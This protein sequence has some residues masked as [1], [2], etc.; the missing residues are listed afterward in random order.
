MTIDVSAYTNKGSRD[1]NEDSMLYTDKLFIVADGLGGHNAGEEASA[2]AVNYIKGNL[3]SSYSESSIMD[4]IE[5]ANTA[6]CNLGSD[7]LTTVAMAIIDKGIFH[8]A[9]V[10]DSRVYLFRKNKLFAYTKDHSVCQVSVDMGELKYED[11]RGNEDRSKLLKVL[12]NPAPVKLKKL[13]QPIRLQDGDA[14]IICTDG[15]WENIYET[16]METDLLKA[17]NAEDW[18]T[19]MIKRLLLKTN[20]IGDNYTAICGIYHNPNAKAAMPVLPDVSRITKLPYFKYIAAGIAALI[21]IIIASAIISSLGSDSTGGGSSENTQITTSITT[22]ESSGETDTEE[23]EAEDLPS[24]TSAPVSESEEITTVTCASISETTAQTTSE[25]VI[26]TTKP[27]T[28][29]VVTTT[30]PP[31][32]TTK[33]K[34]TKPKPSTTTAPK[35]TKPKTTT[36]TE[37]KDEGYATKATTDEDDSFFNDLPETEGPFDSTIPA[38]GGNGG[39]IVYS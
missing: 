39:G 11:I 32:T 15:F 5:K 3:G 13:Y 1:V 7:G 24:E 18:L 9:N 35:S 26:T 31:A 34:T 16:E 12:G 25:T 22:E 23:T 29:P 21:V 33:P 19:L 28:K 27:A 37:E 36:T 14:F 4:L 6:V 17:E 8:Y 10:G 38:P 2:A 30:R 20:D